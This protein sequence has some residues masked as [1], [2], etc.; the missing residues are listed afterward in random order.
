MRTN[1]FC[2]ALFCCGGIKLIALKREHAIS[3]LI[4][5]CEYHENEAAGGA[6]Q[7]PSVRNLV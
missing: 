7:N 6:E 3:D 5:K 1:E 4:A 2:L